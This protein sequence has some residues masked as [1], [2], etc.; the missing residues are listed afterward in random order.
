M[1]KD[2]RK[3]RQDPEQIHM[4]YPGNSH[5]MGLKHLFSDLTEVIL[6]CTVLK[7]MVQLVRGF[8]HQSHAQVADR[9]R[10]KSWES[11]I[12]SADGGGGT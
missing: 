3:E 8:F 12:E 4:A 2:F 6:Y 11:L 7:D 1:Y 10:R 9:T 5:Q